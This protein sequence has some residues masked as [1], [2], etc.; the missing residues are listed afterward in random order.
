MLS[1]G[2]QRPKRQADDSSPPNAEVKNGWNHTSAPPYTFTAYLRTTLPS[3]TLWKIRHSTN[4]D[5]RLADLTQTRLPY[6][7]ANLSW[8]C[9]LQ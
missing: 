3:P 6:E 8:S 2:V 1:P 4:N 5:H 9:S 7:L